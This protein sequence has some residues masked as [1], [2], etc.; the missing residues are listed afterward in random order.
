MAAPNRFYEK[1]TT[2]LPERGIVTLNALAGTPADT[3]RPPL[4]EQPAAV[5][6]VTGT[7]AY[8]PVRTFV[9]PL[10]D[11]YEPVVPGAVPAWESTPRPYSDLYAVIMRL[12]ANRKQ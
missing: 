8:E 6:P 9:D 12:S 5:V 4:F 10:E 7:L 3:S 11:L 2:A 1:H